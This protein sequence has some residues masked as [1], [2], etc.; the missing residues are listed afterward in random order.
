MG[1]A[2][3]QTSPWDEN[4]RR[5]YC[6][7]TG[8]R[9]GIV[10]IRPAGHGVVG[11]R[12]REHEI[13]PQIEPAGHRPLV[14]DARAHRIDLVVHVGGPVEAWVDL[15]VYILVE[16]RREATTGNGGVARHAPHGC[17]VGDG[18]GGI[19]RTRTPGTYILVGVERAGGESI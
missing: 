14:P 10:H 15:G 19:R 12:S 8:D 17:C 6:R 1:G 5:G 2:G 3:R 18:A 9:E 4:Y 13:A 16:H 7:S 11:P